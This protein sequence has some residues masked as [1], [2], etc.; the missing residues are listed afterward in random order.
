M[1]GGHLMWHGSVGSILARGGMFGSRRHLGLRG[2]ILARSYAYA[3]SAHPNGDDPFRSWRILVL[4]L[5]FAKDCQT[6]QYSRT[7]FRREGREL[8]LP[9]VGHSAPSFGRIVNSSQMNPN[10]QV[11]LPRRIELP[12]M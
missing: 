11:V 3:E 9:L 6:I 10:Q 7:E 8:N 12:C 4:L 2:G 5:W 1:D